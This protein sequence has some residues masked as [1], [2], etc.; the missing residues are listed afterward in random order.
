MLHK[1]LNTQTTTPDDWEN[2][3]ESIMGVTRLSENDLPRLQNLLADCEDDDSYLTSPIYYFFTGRKG[4]WVYEKHGAFLL[5]CWHP[6]VAGQILIF[7][8]LINHHVDLVSELLAFIPEPNAGVRIAR[9]KKNDKAILQS[10]NDSGHAFMPC[11]CEENILD[12]K[13]PV[14]ILSTGSVAALTGHRYMYIRNRIRQTHKHSVKVMPCD[15]IHHSKALENLLH[16]WANHNATSA[17][18]Y[19][20]LYS[21]YDN[22]FSLSMEKSSR[23]SGLM[24]FVDDVL[25][26]VGLWDISNHQQKTANLFVSICNT[27]IRG[28]SEF[29]TFK[30]CETLHNQGTQLLNLGGSEW[31]G[32]NTYKNKFCPAISIELK[33]IDVMR[34]AV[35]LPTAFT[36]TQNHA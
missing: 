12:W 11:E 20:N 21:P 4:L 10:L 25:E 1:S 6:N 24:F 26:A 31:Q 29:L 23:L 18:E 17:E 7:P 8:Q 22:L 27:E 3:F 34:D 35:I 28:L 15:A 16:R 30:C 36:K 13:F 33:S 5:V 2:T 14:H 32:L 19:E 9:V